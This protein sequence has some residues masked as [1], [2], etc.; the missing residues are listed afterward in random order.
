MNSKE[1]MEQ[2]FCH[3]GGDN[4]VLTSDQYAHRIRR[5]NNLGDSISSDQVISGTDIDS[6]RIGISLYEDKLT[7]NIIDL[8]DK[9]GLVYAVYV[10]DD[11][12]T[13]ISV[14]P[15]ANKDLLYTQAQP[16]QGNVQIVQGEY[17]VTNSTDQNPILSTFGI[18]SCVGLLLFDPK[19]KLGS[20]AH[21]D[22]SHEIEPTLEEMIDILDRYGAHKLIFGR[23]SNIDPLKEQYLILPKYSHRFSKRIELPKAFS[24]DTRK[25]TIDPYTFSADPTFNRRINEKTDY[26]MEGYITRCFPIY[27]TKSVQPLKSF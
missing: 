27:I 3:L 5:K 12:P 6:K 7:Q 9:K 26:R 18:D 15:N 19:L 13:K 23:T 20:V 4:L 1:L 16:T 24:F 8:L 17:A 10:Y 14:Y 21:V 22:Y 2:L 25:G 11:Y